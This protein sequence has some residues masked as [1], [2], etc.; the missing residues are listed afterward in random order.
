M[1]IDEI[2]IKQEELAEDDTPVDT[3]QTVAITELA[4]TV[5]KTEPI[6][7]QEEYEM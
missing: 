2:V 5:D 6:V 4:E 3:N 1:L 7:K